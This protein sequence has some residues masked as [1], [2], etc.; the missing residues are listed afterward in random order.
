MKV[1]E[2]P[3]ILALNQGHVFTYFTQKF[4]IDEM[5]DKSMES[6]IGRVRYY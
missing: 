3:D 4:D 1:T 6:F 2:L 5:T